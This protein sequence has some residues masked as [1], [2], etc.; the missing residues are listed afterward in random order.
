M[1]KLILFLI[2]ASAFL[3]TLC[4][5]QNV[6]FKQEVTLDTVIPKK[7]PNYRSFD[8]YYIGYGF[9]FD[10]QHF[11]ALET[12]MGSSTQFVFGFRHKTKI[13]NHYAIGYDI[14]Y[15]STGYSIKQSP[16]KSFPTSVNYKSEKLLM[17]NFRLELY[18]RINFGKR[19][20][21]VGKFMD[22]GAF[23]EYG[24]ANALIV[25]DKLPATNA[26]G[27][28]KVKMVNKNPNYVNKLNYGVTAR[29]ANNRVAIY[30]TYRLSEMFLA[31][32]SYPETA[33]LIVGVQ[34]GFH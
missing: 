34:V 30:A 18:N 14:S 27:A 12:V 9:I 15:N 8:H 24:F 1:K 33:N 28:S 23:G 29:I 26:F 10:T 7:G 5:A 32:Y 25:R 31:S 22:I 3:N 17:R 13:N 4:S 6:L 2:I 16:T 19:G 20:N 11:G 21:K